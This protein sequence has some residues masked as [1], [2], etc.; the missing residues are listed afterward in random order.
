VTSRRKLL[1]WSGIGVLALAAVALFS[2]VAGSRSAAKTTSKPDFQVQTFRRGF[3][4]NAFFT[5]DGQSLVFGASW[6]GKPSEIYMKRPDSPE[7]R[8]LGIE[9]AEPLAVSKSGE[10]AILLNRR[11]IQGWMVTGTLARMSLSGGAHREIAENI[12]GAD[13]SPDGS[14]LLAA[15]YAREGGG[16]LEMPL[17]KA[18]YKSAGWIGQPRFSRDGT[19]IAFAEHAILGDDRG[20]VQVLDLKSGKVSKLTKVYSS[21]Q[22]VGWSPDGRRIYFTASDIGSRMLRSVDLS[23]SEQIVLDAPG[24]VT[25]HDVAADGRMLLTTNILRRGLIVLPPGQSEERDISWLDW[26]SPSA[27]SWDGQWLLFEEQAAG[28]GDE[29]YAMYLR[30]TDG[31]PAIHLGEGHA[32]EVSADGKWVLAVLD[33]P[34]RHLALLPV[35]PGSPREI[36]GTAIATDFGHALVPGGKAI[37]FTGKEAGKQG[38]MYQ[39]DLGTGKRSAVTPEG[40]AG[41]FTRVSPDG[42]WLALND[43][44]GGITVYPMEG[45]SP[46]IYPAQGATHPLFPVAFTPD[47]TGVFVQEAGETHATVR[48]LDLATGKWKEWKQ[49]ATKESAGFLDYGPVLVTPDGRGYVYSYRQWLSTLYLADGLDRGTP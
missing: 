17:G 3:V 7:S 47:G 6:D 36:P 26:S 14:Q 49:L 15:V 5:P 35:G 11:I 8:S 28:A 31:S 27:L 2:Y 18:I 43:I 24:A 16:R 29:F 10:L 25:L 42:K 46:R 13:W 23:G 45:G 38:R 22:G 32:R 48:L 1:L 34:S 12:G 44:K 4:S 37:L 40:V 39:V 9:N 30:R 21:L 41:T 20:L 19:K 33:K